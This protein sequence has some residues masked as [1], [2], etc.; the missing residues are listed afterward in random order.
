MGL[1][2]RPS[3]RT[4]TATHPSGFNDVRHLALLIALVGPVPVMA[5]DMVYV[6]VAG[7]K[8]IAA[9]T[10]DPDDG[11]LTPA[12]S[13][14]TSGE[15]GALATD[16]KRRFLFAALRST[17]ELAAFRIE[18][19]NGKLTLINTVPAGADPAHISTDRS[20]RFLL[21]AYYV[22]GKVTVHAIGA[23]GSLGRE[24]RQ[25]LQTKEKAHAI[26]LDPW[27]MGAL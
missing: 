27:E 1:S 23:D 14:S 19:A 21:T 5:A 26:V 3:R 12:G 4:E 11:R 6:S 2:P 16:P 10:L 9:F 25:T 20:G 17:G 15:P 8:R 18:P 22:A 24:P 13:S 7:E